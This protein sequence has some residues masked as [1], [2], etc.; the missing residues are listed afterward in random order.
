M[1]HWTML[2]AQ[3]GVRGIRRAVC[4]CRST[5]GCRRPSR[6][7]RSTRSSTAW[8]RR[9]FPAAG[10]SAAG[11]LA[12]LGRVSASACRRASRRRTCRSAWPAS[13][14]AGFG[15]ASCGWTMSRSRRSSHQGHHLAVVQLELEALVRHHAPFV[16]LLGVG[17]AVDVLAAGAA[18]AGR[19]E[20]QRAAA[21]FQLD[22]VLH[23]AL[24]PGPLADDHRPLVVLQAGRRRSRWRW[25]CSG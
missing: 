14:P 13:S 16:G 6:T 2:G 1:L 20:L 22:H 24:A 19:G 11:L 5:N 9:G 17:E 4:N 7:C 12:G 3:L 18:I 15:S 8:L 10:F 21:V 25:R 23:A